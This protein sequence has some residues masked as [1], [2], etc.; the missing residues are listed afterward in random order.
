MQVLLKRNW[1]NPKGS[2]MRVTGKGTVYEMPEEWKELLPSS[3]EIIEE[4]APVI[5]LVSTKEPDTFSEMNKIAELQAP[6]AEQIQAEAHTAFM[7]AQ[8]KR[9]RQAGA[10]KA[11]EA[12]ALKKENENVEMA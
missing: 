7:K 10:A 3:A 1:F 9:N 4:H 5:P 6:S 11:R 8:T 2:R 12:R